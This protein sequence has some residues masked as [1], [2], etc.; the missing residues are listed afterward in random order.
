MTDKWINNNITCIMGEFERRMV[1]FAKENGVKDFMKLQPTNEE[2]DKIK[3]G[4]KQY[5]NSSLK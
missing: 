3:E 2:L 4:V 1:F 5:F